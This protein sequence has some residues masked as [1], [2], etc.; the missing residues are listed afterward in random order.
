[1]TTK[2]L[3]T[4]KIE[5]GDTTMEEKIP[6]SI[7]LWSKWNHYVIDVMLRLEQRYNLTEAEHDTIGCAEI[8]GKIY[9]KDIET[10]EHNFHEIAG[11]FKDSDFPKKPF[12]RA[13]DEELPA[14]SG[15]V[16]EPQ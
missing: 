16:K 7:L 14:L 9:E 10:I 12:K 8:R 13:D 11:V 2:S 4:I 1:M 5:E 3:D 6:V 15:E